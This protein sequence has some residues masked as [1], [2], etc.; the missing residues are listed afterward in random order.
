MITGATIHAYLQ[1]KSPYDQFDIL[2][3]RRAAFAD[4]GVPDPDNKGQRIIPAT[5][6]LSDTVV[7]SN[8]KQ[9]RADALLLKIEVRHCYEMI[10]PL[11]DAT[12]SEMILLMPFN[13]SAAELACYV[14]HPT[15]DGG[16][17]YGVPIVSQ[18]V[19]RMTAPAIEG[20]FK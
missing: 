13:L 10:F 17:A 9:T 5:G 2:N 3:P 15:V 11:I 19:V 4:F 7:G 16:M 18:A 14:K 12:V 6:L 20:N 1:V 8:S